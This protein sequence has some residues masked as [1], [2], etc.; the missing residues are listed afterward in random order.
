METCLSCLDI[1]CPCISRYIKIDIS[2]LKYI[3]GFIYKL[4]ARECLPSHLPALFH[5]HYCALPFYYHHSNHHYHYYYDND[6]DYYHFVQ[7][8]SVTSDN[9]NSKLWMYQHAAAIQSIIHRFIEYINKPP[10]RFQQQHI[11]Y[12]FVMEV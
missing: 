1:M 8:E 4:L 2:R 12:I 5:V 6:D 11:E 3:N 9:L 10:A 7:T